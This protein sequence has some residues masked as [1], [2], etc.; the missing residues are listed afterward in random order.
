MAYD[1]LGTY[2]IYV[3]PCSHIFGV[4]PYTRVN[5][6]IHLFPKLQGNMRLIMKG[7]KMIDQ[8]PKTVTPLW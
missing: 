8:T 6:R 7:K 3:Q 5:K 2:I 1:L 4:L